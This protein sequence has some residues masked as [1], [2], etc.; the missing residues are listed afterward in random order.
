MGRNGGEVRETSG[1][2]GGGGMHKI[3]CLIGL[4]TLL[5]ETFMSS[6]LISR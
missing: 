5:G 3:H 1:G 2:V 4:I 6:S